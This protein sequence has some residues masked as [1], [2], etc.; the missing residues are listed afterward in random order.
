M[1]HTLKYVRVMKATFVD[2]TA[3]LGEFLG[4]IIWTSVH[5][6]LL[7]FI[8]TILYQNP[9]AELEFGYSLNAILGYFLIATL[10][11]ESLAIYK[12]AW[13]L[14][15]DNL[16]G[17]LTQYL[18]RPINYLA[19]TLAEAIPYSLASFL[20]SLPA[21]ITLF[22][23]FQVPI[24]LNFYIIIG[25]ILSLTVSYLI[26]YFCF[27]LVGM[28]TFYTK[29]IWPTRAIFMA[30]MQVLGGELLPVDL[31]PPLIR[32][33]NFLFPFYLIN[34]IPAQWVLGRIS[35]LELLSS[36]ILGCFWIII[37]ALITKFAWNRSI[38]HFE[39]VGG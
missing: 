30:I 12:V 11:S 38:A 28:T 10:I 32:E 17:N 19:F 3:Y 7:F 2:M 24:E 36:L 35:L 9:Q 27:L 31:L 13:K 4:S 20:V 15:Y 6:F 25:F 22:Y 33:L 34:F 23:V 29:Y 16:N 37:L 39:S 8:W 21:V 26:S 18:A 14:Q 5:F 1:F